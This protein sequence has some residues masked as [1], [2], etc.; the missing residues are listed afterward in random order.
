MLLIDIEM[1][2]SC[3]N[4]PIFDGEYGFCNIL[5]NYNKPSKRDCSSSRQKNCPLIEIP[6]EAIKVE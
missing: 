6:K 5:K 2:K 3:M 1:P 4:C